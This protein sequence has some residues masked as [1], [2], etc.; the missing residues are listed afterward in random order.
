MG[1]AVIYYTPAGIDTT[2]PTPND[3]LIE[4]REFSRTDDQPLDLEPREVFVW[5][6]RATN[7][8]APPA[9][10]NISGGS[11]CVLVFLRYERGFG[12]SVSVSGDAD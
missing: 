10:A 8:P 6:D 9:F 3:I 1:V 12:R 7:R 4:R 11:Q 5:A 2:D